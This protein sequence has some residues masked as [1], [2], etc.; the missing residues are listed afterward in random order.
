[1]RLTKTEI[2]TFQNYKAMENEYNDP[3]IQAT[4][5]LTVEQVCAP[6]RCHYTC[7]G[8]CFAW[9]PEVKANKHSVSA[10]WCWIYSDTAHYI[11][12]EVAPPINFTHLW[13]TN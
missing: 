5:W 6:K 3:F 9:C 7:T 11:G 10:S 4:E 12:N 13:V 2:L 1:M 8:P